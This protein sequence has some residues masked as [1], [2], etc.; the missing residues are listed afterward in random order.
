M[1]KHFAPI[2]GKNIFVTLSLNHTNKSNRR[3]ASSPNFE[4]EKFSSEEDLLKKEAATWKT[5]HA[6]EERFALE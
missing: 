4:Q 3:K 5:I 2:L 1:N 6:P